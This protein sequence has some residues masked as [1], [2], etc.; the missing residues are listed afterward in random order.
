MSRRR[1]RWR[2][3]PFP[4]AESANARPL[5]L[6]ALHRAGGRLYRRRRL[7]AGLPPALRRPLP[8]LRPDADH[9]RADPDRLRHRT[10]RPR[11]PPSPPQ[12][13]PRKIGG[14]AAEIV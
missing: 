14:L 12:S 10:D 5:L 3:D 1:R 4:P 9:H 6:L 7:S 8:Y 13:A 11:R 2:D